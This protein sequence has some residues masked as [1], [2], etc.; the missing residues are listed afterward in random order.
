MMR[1]MN[2]GDMGGVRHGREK[3]IK[4]R[5]VVVTNESGINIGRWS[6]V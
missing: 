5:A 6:G 3:G 1:R 4:V 2:L